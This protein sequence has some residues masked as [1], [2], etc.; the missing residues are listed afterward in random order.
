LFV[1]FL[2]YKPMVSYVNMIISSTQEFAFVIA[3]VSVSNTGS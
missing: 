3:K 1:N 2:N